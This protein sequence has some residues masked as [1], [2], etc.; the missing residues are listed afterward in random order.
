MR[1]YTNSGP[2]VDADDSMVAQADDLKT[3]AA[4]L[5]RDGYLPA[6]YA[7]KCF[8]LAEVRKMVAG[9]E[10]KRAADDEAYRAKRAADYADFLARMNSPEMVARRGT[11]LTPTGWKSPQLIAPSARNLPSFRDYV[12]EAAKNGRKF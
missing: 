2:L 11:F 5:V 7:R 3:R 6:D 12:D 1:I 10:A 9:A 8:N 4:V